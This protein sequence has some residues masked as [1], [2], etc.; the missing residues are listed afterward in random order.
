MNQLVKEGEIYKPPGAISWLAEYTKHYP[1]RRQDAETVFDVNSNIYFYDTT[2]LLHD[3][4]NY[5]VTD[6][7]GLYIMPDYSFC[8]IDSQVD[9]EVAEFLHGKYYLG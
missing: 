9:F 3:H 8:D 6:R 1:T 2:W 5:P 7:T 4:K